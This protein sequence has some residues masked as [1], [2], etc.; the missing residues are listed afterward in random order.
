MSKSHKTTAGTGILRYVVPKHTACNIQESRYG[1]LIGMFIWLLSSTAAV[2]P[3]L[4]RVLSPPGHRIDREQQ[5][6]CKKHKM[7]L[8]PFGKISR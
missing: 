8:S 2:H 6:T 7:C 1:L 5:D 3:F 4:Y